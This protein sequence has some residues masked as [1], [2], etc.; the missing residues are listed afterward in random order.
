MSSE[1]DVPLETLVG[2]LLLGRMEGLGASGVAAFLLGWSSA[3]ELLR[4][5][6]LVLPT[7]DDEVRRA[8]RQLVDTLERAQRAVLEDEPDDA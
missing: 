7:A 1:R 3:L 2:Q 6:D 4:R 8:L 5:T